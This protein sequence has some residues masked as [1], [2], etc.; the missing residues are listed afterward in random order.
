MLPRWTETTK[1]M[2]VI[3]G[4]L[5]V[6]LLVY[7]SQATLLNL[8]LA[9][10][11]A[12]ALY[13]MVAWLHRRL[14][15]PHTLATVT[16]YILLLA[17]LAATVVLLTPIIVRQVQTLQTNIVTLLVESRDW[18]RTTLQTWRIVRVGET[19]VDLSPLVDPALGALGGALPPIPPLDTWLPGLFG[20]IGGL[21][22]TLTSA[23]MAFF[24]TLLYS[25]Y[26]VKD[27]HL[28]Q[29]RVERLVPEA[30]RPEFDELRRRLGLIWRSFFRGQLLFCLV[31]GIL[32]FVL[33]GLLGIPG[34]IP[35]AILVGLLE[36]IPNLGPLIA[37]VPIVIVALISGSSSLALPNIWVAVIA[38]GAYGILQILGSNFLAPLIIGG[39]VDLPP[40]VML[41]GVIVGASVAGLIGAFLATPVLA[42]ARVLAMY[43]YNKVLDRPP[44]PELALPKPPGQAEPAAAQAASSPA[45][46]PS[47]PEGP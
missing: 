30:Y 33:L 43:A 13:P 9:A 36:L 46:E 39:S 19:T 31:M 1:R 20:T 15:F 32:T 27:M 2:V 34:S 35:L 38:I 3:V 45:T 40:L 4:V 8:L 5:L 12:Y 44:F 14:R 16:I 10:V 11:L 6:L 17:I 7:L 24:L 42:S 18:L 47:S 29:E 37:L 41:I 25:F 22:S 28:W 21:A 26:L 23:T